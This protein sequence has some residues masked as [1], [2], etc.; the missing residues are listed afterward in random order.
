MTSWLESLD[1]AEFTDGNGMV[2]WLGNKNW[3]SDETHLFITKHGSIDKK[4]I[5]NV[6]QRINRHASKTLPPNEHIFVVLG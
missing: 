4:V 1:T 6:F 2:H 3:F 5:V